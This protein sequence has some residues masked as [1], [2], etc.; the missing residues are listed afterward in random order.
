MPLCAWFLIC[1]VDILLPQAEEGYLQTKWV[2]IFPNTQYTL[3]ELVITICL[4][5]IIFILSLKMNVL[6]FLT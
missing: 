2:R 5:L 4:L 3:Y 1:I 6:K